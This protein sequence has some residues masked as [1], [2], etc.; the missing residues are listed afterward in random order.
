MRPTYECDGDRRSEERVIKHVAERR[1][2]S[3]KKLPPKYAVD[4]ALLKDAEVKSWAEI[5]CRTVTREKYPTYMLS[6]DKYMSMLRLA[7]VTGLLTELMVLWTDSLGILDITVA[8]TTVSI[9]GRT[10]RND[11]QDTEP[12][13]LIPIEQFAV[14]QRTTAHP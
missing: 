11:A 4:F 10:D 2:L 7:R 9:G 1:G 5:K 14:T 3:Y 6:L 13:A 12:V 8:T